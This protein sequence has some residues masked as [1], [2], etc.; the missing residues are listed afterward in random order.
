MPRPFWFH[1][2]LLPAFLSAGNS[3]G[4]TTAPAR[5]TPK[6]SFIYPTSP[7]AKADTQNL[8]V[9]L[10]LLCLF[11]FLYSGCAFD[12]VNID[13]S[14]TKFQSGQESKSQFQLEEEVKVSFA[15][16][17]STVLKNGT[18][19]NHIGSIPE[20]DVYRTDDQIVTVEASNIYEA[21]I[22]VSS[23]RLL[24]FY[25][26]VESSYAPLSEPEELII[27]LLNSNP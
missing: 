25:L 19:W 7:Q 26:P 23:A 16:G 24:G 20:G 2:S 14:P 21:Y 6:P 12:L 10:F 17:F 22:V 9:R 27:R 15:M 13:Q 18:K 8:V 11:S 5:S 1:A 4:V 3:F